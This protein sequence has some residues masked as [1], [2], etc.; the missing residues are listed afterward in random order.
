MLI[1]KARYP[2]L[3]ETG[4]ISLS[5]AVFGLFIQ[6]PFP[7]RIFSFAGLGVVCFAV[8]YRI[9]TQSHK[10]VALL[11]GFFGLN[12]LGVKAIVYILIS[13]LC[14]VLMGIGLRAWNK[15]PV[16]PKTI[17]FFALSIAPLIGMSEELLF[18]GYIQT[19]LDRVNG[20]AAVLLAAL[21]HTI[22]KSSLVILPALFHG[23]KIPYFAFWTF[24]GGLVFGILSKKSGTVY[25]AL[26]GHAA[27]D[28]IFYSTLQSAPWW[29]W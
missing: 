15:A 13:F 2:L 19:R 12:T 14:G 9:F 26:A 18:R 17:T 8:A 5:M 1:K 24:T 11:A 23:A 22:Y 29:V 21:S 28:I 25:P 16:F 6:T 20:I 3:I 27:F 4:V 7:Y 10:P